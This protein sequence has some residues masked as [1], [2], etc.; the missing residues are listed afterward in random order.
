MGADVG[1][2][3]WGAA[4]AGGAATGA[5]GAGGGGA[6]ARGGGGAAAGAGGAALATP[7]EEGTR[8][9]G[10]AAA[11]LGGMG[12]VSCR[13]KFARYLDLLASKSSCVIKPESI[14][15]RSCCAFKK[16]DLTAS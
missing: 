15:V 14:A 5:G 2:G 7:F 11:A 9:T 12:A 4:A 8:E 10:A 1:T 16:A 13:V 6:G 3:A